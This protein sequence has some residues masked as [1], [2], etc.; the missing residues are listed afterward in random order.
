LANQAPDNKGILVEKGDT[1]TIP[2]GWLTMSLDPSK[3]RGTFTRSGINWFVEFL[4][5]SRFPAGPAKVEG[6]LRDLDKEA[7]EAIINSSRMPGLDP[8]NEAD[9]SRFFEAF[10]DDH[11]S[12]EWRAIMLTVL[13]QRSLKVLADDNCSKEE[14]AFEM[15]RTVGAHVMLVYKQ[16]LE[17]H[18]WAG[19][20][21][22]RLVYEIA[23]AGASTPT[24]AKAIEALRPAFENLSEDVLAAWVGSNASICD[25]LSVKGIDENVVNALARYHL[26]QFERKRQEA[27][28]EGDAKSRKWGN[29]IA[30]A[31]VGATLASVI[32]GLL[33]HLGVFSSSNPGT[34]NTPTPTVSSS[35]SEPSTRPTVSPSHPG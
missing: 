6:F 30:A 1:F 17:S 3:S 26:S 29:L 8:E 24:E 21:Q 11:D 20:E 10:K 19:Y 2:A 22:T 35:L 14:L 23:K 9:M 16:A 25:K 12:I 33:G 5:S 34:L 18:I 32:I 31:A 7:D 28:R 4:I 27:L 15:A 13:A